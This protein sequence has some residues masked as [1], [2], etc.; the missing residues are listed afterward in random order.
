MTLHLIPGRRQKPRHR[1]DDRIADLNAEHATAEAQLRK[2]NVK[3][4]RSLAA[5]DEFFTEQDQRVTA[6]EQELA[7]EQRARAVAEADVETRDRW[8]TDLKR[9]LAD[10][11]RRLDIACQA[12]AAA[13]QTQEI[14]PDT[15]ARICG[16]PVPLFEAPFATTDPGRGLPSWART[17]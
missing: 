1:A 6:L 13:D 16:R 7:A 15:V 17:T 11:Q 9:E 10:A 14:D 4:L 2:Q 5:A 8:I 3:L 12:T